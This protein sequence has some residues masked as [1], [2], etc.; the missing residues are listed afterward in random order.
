MADFKKLTETLEALGYSVRSF[1]T[2]QEAADHI[3]AVLAAD[4]GPIILEK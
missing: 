2:A 3:L 4:N 1:A